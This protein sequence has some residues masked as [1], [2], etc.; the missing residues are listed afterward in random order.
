LKLTPGQLR[1]VLG[2]SADTFRHWRKALSPLTDR[3]GYSPCFAP[4]DLLAV[5][6][7]KTLVERV[8]VRVGALRQ[9]AGPLFQ[10]CNASPWSSFERSTLVLDVSECQLT[11]VAE[12]ERLQAAH[13]AIVLPCGPIIAQLRE[14]LLAGQEFE[15]QQLLRFPPAAVAG[16][17]RAGKSRS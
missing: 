10:A 15:P 3:N 9:I 16:Q 14:A 11:F 17:R 2:L 1:E 4:G 12:R 6:V 8:G 7:I 13:A 5:A